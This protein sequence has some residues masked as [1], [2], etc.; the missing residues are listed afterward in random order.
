MDIKLHF[1]DWSL[2]DTE[3]ARPEWD[4]E[5]CSRYDNNTYTDDHPYPDCIGKI[6]ENLFLGAGSSILK[7]NKFDYFKKWIE[8]NNIKLIISGTNIGN[9]STE[10]VRNLAKTSDI[11]FFETEIEKIRPR[12]ESDDLKDYIPLFK[13]YDEIY[14]LYKE[15]TA[16]EDNNILV[17]CRAGQD[18][19]ALIVQSI[20]LNI[21]IEKSIYP[22]I[23]SN[24]NYMK[25]F[26]PDVAA[27][28]N[29][30]NN[31]IYLNKYLNY[32]IAKTYL[33]LINI[34]DSVRR[35]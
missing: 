8:D 21:E 24:F 34:F 28:P 13:V 9:D 29:K 20:L 23:S 5:P 4:Y 15:I 12:I 3:G 6:T 26:R 14:E 31:R 19:S 30:E 7:P 32:K 33:N 11:I 2:T 10:Y 25:Q 18:R 1:P 17:Y 16:S 35:N 22:N 27:A